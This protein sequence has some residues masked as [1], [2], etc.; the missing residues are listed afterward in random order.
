MLVAN[1]GLVTPQFRCAARGKTRLMDGNFKPMEPVPWPAP[2]D[3]PGFVHQ[4]KWD[5]VRI[6]ARIG[7]DGV[8]LRTRRGGDRTDNYPEL[9]ALSSLLRGKDVLLDG[10]AVVL[11]DEGRPSFARILRRDQAGTVTTALRRRL[12]V[13]YVVFDILV[14]NGAPLLDRPFA[15]RHAILA[16]LIPTE[17]RVAVCNNHPEGVELFAATGRMGLEGIVSKELAGRYHPGRKHSTW[18]KV[19]HFRR[20]NAVVG[21]VLLK[22]GRANALLLG[23]YDERG[24]V[25]VGRAATGLSGKDLSA[26]TD[27][28]RNHPAPHS[29]FAGQGRVTAERDLE[30]VWLAVRPTIVVRYTGWTEQARLRN[31]VIVGFGELPA[32]ECIFP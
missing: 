5:G 13:H 14:L 25:Y 17:E 22:Q 7:A 9:H 4:V 11:D 23:L 18:R 32:E 12:P 2:F 28:A 20:L 1:K 30:V 24:L 10:E 26:L 16:G 31:P 27:L 29:P 15:E 8:T 21:G 6:L 3:A 19:K